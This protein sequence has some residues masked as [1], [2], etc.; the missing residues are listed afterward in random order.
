M[1]KLCGH[2]KN[3]K[4]L[5]ML[6]VEGKRRGEEREVEGRG[7]EGIEGKERVGEKGRE[8]KGGREKKEEGRAWKEGG[9]E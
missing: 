9:D 1:A 2:E 4:V 6:V 8:R 5:S 3:C 7:R